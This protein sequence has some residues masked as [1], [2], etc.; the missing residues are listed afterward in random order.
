MGT[1]TTAKW[2]HKEEQ[3]LSA[4]NPETKQNLS[5]G[6]DRSQSKSARSGSSA[7]G[8]DKKSTGIEPKRRFFS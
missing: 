2:D 1:V 8:R 3:L 5:P 4:S 7:E 6:E